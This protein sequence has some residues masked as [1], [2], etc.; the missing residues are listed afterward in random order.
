MLD[1][2]H[3]PKGGTVHV[4]EKTNKDEPFIYSSWL[5]SYRPSKANNG[6]NKSVYFPYQTGIIEK[7]L[8]RPNVKVNIACSC[9]DD[10]HLL[11]YL[12]SEMSDPN[13]RFIVH[14]LYVKQAYR[15]MGLA[16][17]LLSQATA[18]WLYP[19]SCSHWPASEDLTNAIKELNIVYDPRQ[20]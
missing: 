15:R 7:I 8:A 19:I 14:Y 17:S 9:D 2:I 10:T 12:V 18:D 5:H 11:G 13:D 20:R 3:L 1:K 4:R 6:M 16:T